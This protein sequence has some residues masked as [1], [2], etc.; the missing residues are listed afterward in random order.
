L[1]LKEYLALNA[2][3]L[4]KKINLE[5]VPLD[6]LL[7]RHPEDPLGLRFVATH[8]CFSIAK[9]QCE[10]GYEPEYTPEEAIAETA[11]L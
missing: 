1:P 4:G 7:R 8:M 3:T 10:I 11:R 6:E 2:E 9:A 5:Y